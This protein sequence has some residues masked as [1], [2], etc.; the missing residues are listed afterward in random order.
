MAKK[1]YLAEE[2]LNR[3]VLNIKA[4]VAK[5]AMTK[6]GGIIEGSLT[7][8]PDSDPESYH[9][10]RVRNIVMSDSIS[11]ITEPGDVLHVYE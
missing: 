6:S 1:K 9:D 2:G 11:T 4:F 5:T 10:R 3:L 7:I 8:A